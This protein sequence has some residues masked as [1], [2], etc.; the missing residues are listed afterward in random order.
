MVKSEGEKAMYHKAEGNTDKK[1]GAVRR[2]ARDGRRQPTDL[3]VACKYRDDLLGHLY[4][5]QQTVYD[6][7]RTELRVS[8]CQQSPP[9]PWSETYVCHSP[10]ASNRMLTRASTEVEELMIFM[11]LGSAPHQLEASPHGA[12]S[13]GSISGNVHIWVRAAWKD[14]GRIVLRKPR[15]RHGRRSHSASA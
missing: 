5:D 8:V 15:R 14:E 4:V 6:R 12:L 7:N 3:T 9:G 11:V 1:E 2:Y 10:N 13:D